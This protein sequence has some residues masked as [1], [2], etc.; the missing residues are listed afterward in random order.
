[1]LLVLKNTKAKLTSKDMNTDMILGE[2]KRVL[3]ELLNHDVNKAEKIALLDKNV[4]DN[5]DVKSLSSSVFRHILDEI[6]N[7]I[8]PFIDDKSTAG[9][10]LLN[11]FFVT[12]NK[13]VGKADKNQAFTPDHITDFMVKAIN[14][15]R[16]SIVLDPTCGS[17]SFLV[18]AMT[19]AL[20]DAATAEEQEKIK[21]HQIYGIE[22]DENIYG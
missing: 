16:N 18:R 3:G 22:Y 5:Q 19:Q 11:L 21:K 17:G 15:N 7:K 14:V 20:N 2:M 13:Y 8:L 1:C 12:F 9:Q 6:K 4:L 10:D